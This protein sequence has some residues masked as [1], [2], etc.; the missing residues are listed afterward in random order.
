MAG[1]GRREIE[2]M[3]ALCSHTMDK[4]KRRDWSNAQLRKIVT[5]L[6][7]YIKNICSCLLWV[8]KIPCGSQILVWMLCWEIDMKTEHKMSSL[9]KQ[10]PEHLY[11]LLWG[12]QKDFSGWKKV[13]TGVTKNPLKFWAP[14]H[15]QR[16]NTNNPNLTVHIGVT[17]GGE[18][19]RRR[20][21]P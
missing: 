12:T 7:W 1:F 5:V 9:I 14:S 3:Q 19:K 8:S 15:L 20:C 10:M 11:K 6:F 16:K 21:P 2:Y 4:I 18:A 17:G 13:F